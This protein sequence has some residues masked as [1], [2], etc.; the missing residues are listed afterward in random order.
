MAQRSGHGY[1]RKS[2]GANETVH[3]I[4]HFHWIHYALAYGALIVSVI[5]GIF[6]GFSSQSFLIGIDLPVVGAVIFLAIMIPIWTT[7][8]GVTNQRVIYKKG[9]ISRETSEIQLGAIEEV[10][11]RCQDRARPHLGLWHTRNPRHR[12]GADRPPRP[13]RPAGIAQGAAGS[14]RRNQPGDRAGQQ[15]R[16]SAARSGVIACIPSRRRR[17]LA[18]LPERY[19]KSGWFCPCRACLPS[20]DQTKQVFVGYPTK[21]LLRFFVGAS[22]LAKTGKTI[23]AFAGTCFSQ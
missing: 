11:L 3:Y 19:G 10:S 20:A 23:P 17:T 4:A 16:S 14:D 8:I 15:R 13:R 21:D 7:E 12:R 5:L 6:L 2:L 1:I 18:S 22:F 9:L